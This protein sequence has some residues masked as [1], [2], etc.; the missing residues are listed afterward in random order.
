MTMDKCTGAKFGVM[1]LL[2]ISIIFI[3]GCSLRNRIIY[4]ESRPKDDG[5]SSSPSVIIDENK[6][7]HKNEWAEIVNYKVGATSED[8]ETLY[9]EGKFRIKDVQVY[10]SISEAGINMDDPHIS[11]DEMYQ[12]LKKGDHKNWDK[13]I[14]FTSDMGFPFVLVAME[15]EAIKWSDP[16]VTIFELAF[17]QADSIVGTYYLPMYYDKANIEKESNFYNIDIIP[18]KQEEITIG[19]M[20]NPDETPLSELGILCPTATSNPSLQRFVPLGLQGNN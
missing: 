4:T 19:F 16:S 13:S 2:I 9:T 6:I 7:C 10:E 11:S 8:G 12:V 18:G 1:V 20:I 17:R 15:V 5:N 14:N 3:A